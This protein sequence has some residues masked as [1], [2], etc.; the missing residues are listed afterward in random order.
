LRNAE[1]A[2]KDSTHA[3]EKQRGKLSTHKANLEVEE[4][5]LEKVQEGLRGKILIT[6]D[7][8][9]AIELIHLKG[10]TQVFHDQIQKKQK[11]LQPWKSKI[12][13][14]EAAIE[15]R[16]GERETLQDRADKRREALDEAQMTFDDLVREQEARVI[17][18]ST[19]VLLQR[20]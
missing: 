9:R 7:F 4:A 6:S 11:E 18:F 3:L 15:I 19:P 14:A 16:A 20:C 8:Q 12:D 2:D 13:A 10:K 17:I 1:E 5:E